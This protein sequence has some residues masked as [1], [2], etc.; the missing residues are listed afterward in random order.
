MGASADTGPTQKVVQRRRPPFGARDYERNWCGM[1]FGQRLRGLRRDLDL[2]QAEIADRGG[3]SVNTVRKLESDERRPSRELATRLAEV[4]ELSPRERADFLRLARGTQSVT[5]PSLPSPMTRLIGREQDIARIRERLVG[6]DVRLLTLVGPPGVGKTRLALQLATDLQE[7]FRDGAAFVAL[8]TVRDPEL[9][10]ETIAQALGVRGTASRSL[11]QA[12]AEHLSARQLLLVLDNFEQIL[13]ARA[14]V[15]EMLAAAAK[16]TVL[17]TS[18]EALAVYGEHVYG[19]PTLEL[20]DLDLRHTNGRRRLAPRS[21]A[22]TLFLERARAARPNFA[23]DVQDQPVVAE[24]CLRLEGLPLAMELAATRAKTMSPRALLEQLGQRLELL[25]AGPA[26]FSPRQRS[27]RG[28]LDWSYDLLNDD[29]RAVFGRMST[30][31]GGATLDAVAEVCTEDVRS[32]HVVKLA[33]ESLAEKSLLYVSEVADQTRFEM[34][35]IVRE[36]ALERLTTSDEPALHR[37][38]AKFFATFAEQA[39]AK[40]RESDQLL[41][42][43]RLEADHD[44]LRAALDWVLR[45]DE[46]ELAGRLCA[47]LWPF[48]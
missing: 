19:V 35:E 5:R 17:V 34:L 9:V 10:T 24:I 25:S 2:S 29:A 28:A 16:L 33:V 41:W 45:S 43:Q 40:L 11:E 6:V 8:A 12:L 46:A 4:F 13:S 42:L 14:Y 23:N 21:P 30:F 48:W 38:H 22:E 47:A 36:Y 20:P 3:C 27:I 37:R 26:D 32:A 15:A 31:A 39:Q 44:N 7:V 18:R 1:S